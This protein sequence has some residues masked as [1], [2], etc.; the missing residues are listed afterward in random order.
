M[1]DMLNIAGCK[2]LTS[3]IL[4]NMRLFVASA[5]ANEYNA[6]KNFAGQI[7]YDAENLKSFIP[8]A[9]CP[10]WLNSAILK[11]RE[12]ARLGNLSSGD[13]S[14]SAMVIQEIWFEARKFSWDQWASQ[15]DY[16]DLDKEF[17]KEA[18]ACHLDS[19]ID[20]LIECLNI[21]SN[22]PEFN[23]SRQTTIDIQALVGNLEKSKN[24][25]KSAI[26][27]WLYT[28][29]ELIKLFIPHIDKFEK[30]VELLKKTSAAYNEVCEIIDESSRVVALGLKNKFCFGE[31]IIP[32]G[33]ETPRLSLPCNL[34]DGDKQ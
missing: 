18:A 32:L 12:F 1:S 34:E 22:D 26:M 29:G 17:A 10:S 2:E 25:S 24:A 6:A 19:A 7:A 20:R 9:T 27:S 8:D 3:R 23:L 21:I 15:Y 4:E 31:K 33:V 14:K 28:A 30:G 13:F 16:T 11:C 5:M